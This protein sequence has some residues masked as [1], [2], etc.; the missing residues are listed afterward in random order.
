MTVYPA[1][2]SKLGKYKVFKQH[3]EKFKPLSERLYDP[4]NKDEEKEMYAIIDKTYEELYER[5]KH[6]G[7]GKYYPNDSGTIPEIDQQVGSGSEKPKG[8]NEEESIYLRESESEQYDLS[9]DNKKAI[10]RL[11]TL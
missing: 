4:W 6:K 5:F 10:E 3:F 9:S 2:Q 8:I 1:F 7:F 11:K